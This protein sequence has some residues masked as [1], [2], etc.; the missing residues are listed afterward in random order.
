[1]VPRKIITASLSGS[2]YPVLLGLIV[3]DIFGEGIDSLSDYFVSA[4]SIVPIY[5]MYSFPAILV[6][7][8][9]TSILSDKAGGFIAARTGEKKAEFIV[10]AA[11]HSV[12]GLVLLWFSLGAA[13]LFFITDRILKRFDK[14]YGWHH[15][16]KS[17]AIPVL[18]WLLFMGFVW[19]WDLYFK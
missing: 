4:I 1:M 3:P 11:L 8:V 5:M 10:S 14:S 12:F 9:L 15:A 7:G 18:T 6:Y 17:L 2:L 19:V 16:F 13:V